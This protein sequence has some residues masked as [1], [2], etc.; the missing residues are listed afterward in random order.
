M[1]SSSANLGWLELG[2]NRL[3]HIPSHA[4]RPLHSL[5]HIDLDAN[6]I[7]YLEE[8]AFSGYGDSLKFIVL[9]KNQ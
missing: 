5:R 4:L 9:D 6:F 7:Q 8:D 1:F 3:D 2:S